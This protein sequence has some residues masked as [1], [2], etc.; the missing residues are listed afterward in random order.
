MEILVIGG[1]QFVGLRLV[2]ELHRRGHDITL[3]NRGK[4]EA[5]LPDGIERLYA[6]RR[7]PDEV[8][9][10]LS[11]KI[12]EAVFDIIGYYEQDV[13]LMMDVL[14]GN[15]AH[16]IF[17]STASVYQS[18][19]VFPIKEDFPLWQEKTPDDPFYS[20]YGY[21]KVL[22]E[23]A[24]MEQDDFEATV[25]RPMYIYGPFN[26]IY[27]E[28]YFYD[29][30]TKDRPILIPGHQN[31]ILQFGHVDDLAKA[32]C[33]TLQNEDAYGKA[34]NISGA[35]YVTLN[36]LTNAIA[37][38]L[39][40][41]V[42]IIRYDIDLVKDVKSDYKNPIFPFD[43]KNNM[44]EDISAAQENLNWTP[45]YDL[46]S[47]MKMTFEWYNEQGL[48]SVEPNFDIDDALQGLV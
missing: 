34:F 6:D 31:N 32:F 10:A 30:I 47:G 20:D 29:R 46:V 3:L 41:S 38:A 14:R 9:E 48:D 19:E 43:W 23:N 18:T 8:K 40:K 24:V 22:C 13:K 2:W 17:C 44:F 28:R 36:G 15:I 11:G 27:R 35:E 39:D 1:T 5:E 4:T 33:Q 42:E 16:Y 25:I 21:N 7:K 45:E 12:F 26:P 37:R